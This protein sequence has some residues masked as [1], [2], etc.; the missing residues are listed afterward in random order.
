MHNRSGSSTQATIYQAIECNHY[1]VSAVL[2]WAIS[3]V[4]NKPT[5]AIVCANQHS[6][7]AGFAAQ[8]GFDLMYYADESKL[9]RYGFWYWNE[10]RS[11]GYEQYLLGD[12]NLEYHM[13]PRV[14]AGFEQLSHSPEKIR[15]V[16][17][18]EQYFAVKHV[19]WVHIAYDNVLA[20]L[21]GLSNRINQDLPVVTLSGKAISASIK[22]YKTYFSGL[23]YV[24]YDSG[25]QPLDESN[26]IWRSSTML[27]AI[28]AHSN[29]LDLLTK[30]TKFSNVLNYANTDRH[31]AEHI[32]RYYLSLLNYE[33][34]STRLLESCLF[35]DNN[36]V[37]LDTFFSK[38]LHPLERYENQQW[39]WSGAARQSIIQLAIPAAGYYFLRIHLGDLPNSLE[40]N[41]VSVFLNGKQV[42]FESVYS[43]SVIEFG[44]N[45]EPVGFD[46][47]AILVLET[48]K[49]VTIDGK[50]MG[51]AI[52]K[53]E[54]FVPKDE[55][56]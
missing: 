47:N 52:N 10:S 12:E 51:I 31:Q 21:K 35:A 4:I 5:T 22:E 1:H 54:M 39:R 40:S 28:P 18:D 25:L 32:K 37:P 9:K 43:G 26:E 15:K 23:G 36:N 44:V 33:T 2:N 17:F 13:T 16:R 6:M 29:V 50:T 8:A 41:L 56:Q 48:D 49:L 19:S 11:F 3:L 53:L 38:G 46:E 7:M 45:F 27:I 30:A 24:I 14:E 34:K 42:A 55:L 20:I